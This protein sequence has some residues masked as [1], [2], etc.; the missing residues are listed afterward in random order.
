MRSLANTKVQ[1]EGEIVLDEYGDPIA[2][3]GAERGNP[4]PASLI[5]RRQLVADPSDNA[6]LTYIRYAVLRARPNT[7]IRQDDIVKDL[8]TGRRWIVDEITQLHN[9][10]TGM[11]LRCQLRR[12]SS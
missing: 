1:I 6:K 8:K 4:F 7:D 5:E 11:D 3:S 12:A 9:P 10:L 2:G